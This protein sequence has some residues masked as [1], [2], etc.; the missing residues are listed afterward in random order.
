MISLVHTF[1]R[2]G[3]LWRTPAQIAYWRSCVR[4]S[5]VN[6]ELSIED[7]LYVTRLYMGLQKRLLLGAC[8]HDK[9]KKHEK[10]RK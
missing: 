2:L 10:G 1:P 7:S 4:D 9:G 8:R 6:C 3:G 5:F